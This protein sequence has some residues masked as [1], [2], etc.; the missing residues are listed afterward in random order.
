MGF[1]GNHA[2]SHSP[3]ELFLKTHSFRIQGVPINNLAFMKPKLDAGVITLRENAVFET[4][5]E[6]TKFS[7]Y[8]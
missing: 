2:F 4:Y 3:N 5:T 7:N 1:H 8:L 6:G